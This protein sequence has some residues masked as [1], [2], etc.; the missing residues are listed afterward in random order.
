MNTQE[1][2]RADLLEQIDKQRNKQTEKQAYDQ[3][4]GT[5]GIIKIKIFESHYIWQRFSI[6]EKGIKSPT[7]VLKKRQLQDLF[8]GIFW[9]TGVLNYSNRVK[10]RK[11]L[12]ESEKFEFCRHS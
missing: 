1:S 3:Q 10:Q 5:E 4:I 9:F 2:K 8:S 11:L 12:L 6:H 7:G